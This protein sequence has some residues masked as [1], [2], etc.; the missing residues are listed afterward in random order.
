MCY[1]DAKIVI[2]KMKEQSVFKEGKYIYDKNS[3]FELKVN[4]IDIN[5]SNQ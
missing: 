3:F 2:F 5:S 4:S 1:V